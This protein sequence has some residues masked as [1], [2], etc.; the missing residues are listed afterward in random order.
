MPRLWAERLQQ[1]AIAD[2]CDIGSSS[3]YLQFVRREIRQNAP[4]EFWRETRPEAPAENAA[5]VWTW[6]FASAAAAGLHA[7]WGMN[8]PL[9]CFS[10]PGK[11]KGSPY[12]ITERRVPELIAVL[13]SQSACR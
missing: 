4:G 12:S 7:V 11:D 2:R 10:L 9:A 8:I 6:H 5:R 3:V 1:Q 13:G